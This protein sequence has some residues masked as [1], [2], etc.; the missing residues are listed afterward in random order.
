M[1]CSAAEDEDKEEGEALSQMGEAA[2]AAHTPQGV[3]KKTQQLLQQTPL[4]L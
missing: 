4:P 3:S 1:C 2:K